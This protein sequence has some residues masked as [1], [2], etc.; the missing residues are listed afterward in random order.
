LAV[1][2]IEFRSA[3]KEA[4]GRNILID[5]ILRNKLIYTNINYLKLQCLYRLILVFSRTDH[6][7]TD[8]I[9]ARDK[10]PNILNIDAIALWGL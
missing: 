5:L 10:N 2:S 8:P 4:V 1:N 9:G 3:R 6:L 7:L